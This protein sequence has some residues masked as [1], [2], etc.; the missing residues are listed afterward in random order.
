MRCAV[1]LSG[2]IL[3]DRAV[4]TWLESADRLI[5]ADGGARH[6]HRMNIRPDLLVGDLDS[7]SSEELNWLES[8]QV[9]I[10]RFPAAKNETDA[11]LAIRAALTDLPEPNS[12]HELVIL[13]AFGSRPD[14]VLA[15]QLLAARLAGEGWCLILTDGSSTAFTLI[16]GQT[17]R[18]NLPVHE[19]QALA[20]SAIPITAE[21]TGLTYQGLT[22][23]LTNATLNLGSTRGLSNNLSS[24]PA[25]ATLA[26]GILLIIVTPED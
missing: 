26:T 11:E 21:I 18:L 20:I 7:I 9:P 16:G 24:S 19:E 1:I 15:N 3:D 10:K 12:Q 25:T 14:H 2:S 13:G 23:P 22:Y 5:C 8:L 6:L 4:R 17:L